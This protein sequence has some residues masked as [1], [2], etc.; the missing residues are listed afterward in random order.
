MKWLDKGFNA[1]DK[2]SISDLEAQEKQD[3]C[4]HKCRMKIKGM[5]SL[6]DHLT[7]CN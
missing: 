2:I 3:I 5:P 4:C 1:K 7:K 6:K